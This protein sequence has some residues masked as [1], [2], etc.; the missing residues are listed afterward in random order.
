[1]EGLA[2]AGLGTSDRPRSCVLCMDASGA[3]ATAGFCKDATDA[4]AGA[5]EAGAATIGADGASEDGGL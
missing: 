1:M 5:T 2:W 3:S 4:G